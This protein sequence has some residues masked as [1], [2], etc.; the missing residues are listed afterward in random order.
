MKL[1]I[2]LFTALVIASS[3]AA[4]QIP[5]TDIAH[6]GTSV[7]NW[8]A[9]AG[10]WVTSEGNQLDQITNQIEQ[11]SQMKT[12]LERMGDPSALKGQ[13]GLDQL[14]EISRLTE[15]GKSYQSLASSADPSTYLSRIGASTS[16]SGG[17]VK[18]PE[19]YRQYATHAAIADDYKARSEN[20]AKAKGKL[21]Q[22]MDQTSRDLDAATTDS[23]VQRAAAKMAV[24][25]GQMAALNNEDVAAAAQSTIEANNVEID[26]RAKTQAEAE[27]MDAQREEAMKSAAQGTVPEPKPFQNPL[28]K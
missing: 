22:E 23:E 17:S 20:A 11:I 12:E 26:R 13:L 5:V 3:R 24:L 19:T 28:L 16:G 6:I 15:Q 1:T 8:I 21:Q 4:A 25:Q 18:N 27:K 9:E 10:E 7:S 2:I 14:L